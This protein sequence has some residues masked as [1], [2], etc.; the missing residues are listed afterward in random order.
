M[1]S[2]APRW[3]VRIAINPEHWEL[4]QARLTDFPVE[5]I[6]ETEDD[7]R[8]YFAAKAE[9]EECAREFGVA[10][11]QMTSAGGGEVFGDEPH[12]TTALCVELLRRAVKPG[13]RVADIG[14]GTG[15]LSRTAAECQ[16][17]FAVGCDIDAPAARRTLA[18]AAA[19]QG[20]ADCLRSG[21]FHVVAANLHLAALRTVWPDLARIA[22]PQANVVLGGLLDAHRGEVVTLLATAGFD[23]ALELQSGDWLAILASRL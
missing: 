22:R 3:F 7:A 4:D 2:T 1:D 8:V 5:A 19:I 20:S 12:P 9:A 14:S 15:I 21:E 16:A 23:V 11:P 13:D 17:A 18:H 10:A 6:I